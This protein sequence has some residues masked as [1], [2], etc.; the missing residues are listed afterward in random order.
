M[1]LTDIN[2]IS[3]YN[4]CLQHL[5][6][7]GFFQKKLLAI[8][9]SFW[10]FAGIVRTIFN[11]EVFCNSNEDLPFMTLSIML[12]IFS[13]AYLS[14]YYN[15]RIIMFGLS[16]IYSLGGL[17]LILSFAEDWIIKIGLYMVSFAQYSICILASCV[18]F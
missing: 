3:K 15:R 12:G 7:F 17:L 6:P 11:K 2:S 4:K 9:I 8:S 13:S 5:N 16:A 10:I 18:L 1:N 14:Y